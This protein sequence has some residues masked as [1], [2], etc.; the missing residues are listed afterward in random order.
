MTP[1]DGKAFEQGRFSYKDL[2]SIRLK[3]YRNGNWR[4]LTLVEKAL[5]KASIELA[6]LRGVL[7]NPALLKKLRNIVLKL[8]QASTVRLLQLGMDY[9]NYLIKIY[10]RNGV[11]G[12]FPKIRNLLKDPEYLLWLGVKQTFIKSTG[13][14]R[15]DSTVEQTLVLTRGP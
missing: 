7:V 6:K 13:W 2:A 11:A 1:A 15:F 4:R 10:D 3:A 14:S 8:L 12:W 5:F 9:A